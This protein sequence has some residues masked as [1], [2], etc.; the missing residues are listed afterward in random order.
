MSST[1][2][3]PDTSSTTQPSS[4]T[5]GAEPAHPDSSNPHNPN[6]TQNPHIDYPELNAYVDAA[7]QA[8]IAP[9]IARTVIEATE[10]YFYEKSKMAARK[11]RTGT[12]CR[13]GHFLTP[14]LLRT[15]PTTGYQSCKAC[16]R[17][18]SAKR[19]GQTP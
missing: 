9:V 4:P 12:T 14:D 3:T 10:R 7:V 8:A 1:T 2:G 17:D 6:P 18:R 11:D 15:N 13:N 19:R 5:T 16:H